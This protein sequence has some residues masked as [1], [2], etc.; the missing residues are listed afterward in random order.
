MQKINFTRN[1][2]QFIIEEL[3]E[4]IL[5]FSQRTVGVL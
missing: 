4:T 1:V 2:D 5:Y 3:K